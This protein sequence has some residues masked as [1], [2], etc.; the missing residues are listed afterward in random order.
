VDEQTSSR[1]RSVSHSARKVSVVRLDAGGELA[2]GFEL[3][4]QQVPSLLP[5]SLPKQIVIKPNLCDIT[6]WETGVTTD[7]QWLAVL[8][9]QI[10]SIRPDARIRVVES[11]AI[12]A[13]KS[14][15]SCDETFER[16]GFVSVAREEGIELV[17]VSRT[18]T[19]E[20][21]P[22]RLLSPVRVPQILLEEIY[23]V[24]VANL[25]VHPYTRMTGVLKNS[26]GL[27]ADPDISGFHPYLSILI[28]RLHLLCPPDLC[29][30]DGRIGLQG[31]G[32]I[33]GDPLR[34][35]TLILGNDALAVDETACRLMGIPVP[36]VPYLCQTA[37]DLGRQFGEF[38]VVGDLR[39]RTFTFDA[40]SSHPAILAKF[41]SRRL[42][43]RMA[44]LSNRW[45]DRA[46]RFR[47]EP[48]N[49]MK[50]AISKLT[51]SQ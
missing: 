16:L 39:S 49:F 8:A 6:A 15:R 31:K 45:I 41:A 2:R 11:D 13:Y 26:L 46:Y 4:L 42:H 23:F 33:I 1:I 21:L 47:R 17:N 24:S 30:I 40:A 28:S 35:D 22:E 43:D 14:Y 27:L 19:I 7:P 12:S 38:E 51:R 48:R 18:D 3:A 32:P 37:R 29:I 10:R 20:I 50:G 5:A 34:M 9:R 44:A 36:Q 25:K